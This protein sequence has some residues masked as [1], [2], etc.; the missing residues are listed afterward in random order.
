MAEINQKNRPRREPCTRNPETCGCS[1]P[2]KHMHSH[3]NCMDAVEIGFQ[4]PYDVKVY[5]IT[6]EIKK[7]EFIIQDDWF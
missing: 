7:T 6:K 2:R 5:E 3:C 1:E 4:C